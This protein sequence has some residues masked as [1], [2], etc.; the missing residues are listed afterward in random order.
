MGNLGEIIPVII[1]GGGAVVLGLSY[2]AVYLM[3]KN[4]GRKELQWRDAREASPQTDRL[5]RVEAAVESIALGV[6]RLGE[7]QRYMLGS[8][9]EGL[10][11]DKQPVKPLANAERRHPTPVRTPPSA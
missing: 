7:G 11:S 10:R 8:F 9:S 1:F 4:A 6:E 5:D 2:V 3:G